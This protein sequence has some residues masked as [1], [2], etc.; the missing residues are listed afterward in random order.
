M[1][2]TLTNRRYNPRIGILSGVFFK[3]FSVLG[4]WYDRHCER[5][6]LGELPRHMLRDIGLTDAQAAK[7]ASKP[8]WMA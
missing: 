5:V 3:V 4:F 8:F 7:E 1:S 6:Q 2:H